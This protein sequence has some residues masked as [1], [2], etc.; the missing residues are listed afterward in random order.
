MEFERERK[1]RIHLEIAPLV[2]IV[3][4]L[5]IFFMLTSNF[6]MQPGIKI[7]LPRAKISR[8]QQE[9]IVVFITKDNRIY[10]NDREVDIGELKDALKK[11][12][13]KSK[14]KNVILKADEKINLGLAVKVMDIAKQAKAENVV[15]STKIEHQDTDTL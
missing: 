6:I 2:D 1:I 9:D 13:E 5:L 10:F 8:P 4:L 7:T 12:L 11:K 14:K 3:L 15:I